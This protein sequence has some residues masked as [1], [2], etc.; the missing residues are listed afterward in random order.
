MTR[1]DLVGVPRGD[2][3]CD[4]LACHRRA[5]VAERGLGFR[6]RGEQFRLVHTHGRRLEGWASAGPA[7]N[8]VLLQMGTPGAGIPYEPMV[9]AVVA[10]GHRFVTYSRPGYGGSSR[11]AG[12]SVAD[13]IE[14]VSAVIQH[15]GLDR[16]HVV[17][18]S[19]GGPH[20]LACAARLPS[21]AS[22]ATLAGVAPSNA[23]G[24]DWLDGMGEENVRELGAALEGSDALVSYLR[25]AAD[26]LRESTGATIAKALGTLVTEV[27][28]RA[29]TGS[30]A[31]FLARTMHEALADGVGG[32]HD[33][34]LAFARDWGFSLDEIG[35]PVTVWQGRND[36][37]VPF[38]HGRWLAE[39]VT[40][41]RPMLLEDEGHISLVAR[42]DD[43][44]ED[45]LRG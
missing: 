38:A 9:A 36:A 43:V 6:M 33:D 26:E 8:A 19:G 22:A 40:G 20:A 17:G 31:D 29:L 23:D 7:R 24:L 5:M 27:D 28:R 34:D 13:C 18:W 10:R 45:L 16:V 37:M 32:W 4:S 25:D 41:A 42:F 15:L 2:L 12:R 44:V 3:E 1:A 35:V 14:D 11:W 21:V 30:L 39:H